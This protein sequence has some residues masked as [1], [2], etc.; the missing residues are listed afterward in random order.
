LYAAAPSAAQMMINANPTTQVPLLEPPT[1][2][3]GAYDALLEQ[4]G[5]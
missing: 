5:T 3:L 1:V 4:V 2:D